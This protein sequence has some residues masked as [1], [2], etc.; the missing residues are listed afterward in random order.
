ME[1]IIE[2]VLGHYHGEPLGDLRLHFPSREHKSP[3]E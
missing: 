1:S 3:S 2:V